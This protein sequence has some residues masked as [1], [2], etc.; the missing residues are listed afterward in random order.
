MNAPITY[1]RES[2][3]QRAPELFKLRI[4]KCPDC[5]GLTY[6][7]FTGSP[8]GARWDP[9]SSTPRKIDC[10]GRVVSETEG[11]GGASTHRP[12]GETP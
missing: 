9:R 2:D 10:V 1:S 11:S 7:T 6:E 12:P 8:H 4:V 5:G 3:W